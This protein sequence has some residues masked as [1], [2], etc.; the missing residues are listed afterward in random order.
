MAKDSSMFRRWGE[1]SRAFDNFRLDDYQVDSTINLEHSRSFR[2]ARFIEIFELQRFSIV[3]VFDYGLDFDMHRRSLPFVDNFE[4][5]GR[6]TIE[7]YLTDRGRGNLYPSTLIL[8]HLPLDRFNAVLSS[9][10][11]LCRQLQLHLSLGVGNSGVSSCLARCD[12]KGVSLSGHLSELVIENNRGAD[13]QQR[14][15]YSES[16]CDPLKSSHGILAVA[17]L[18]S[19]AFLVGFGMYRFYRGGS[20]T[21]L[22]V[23][24][25][26]SCSDRSSSLMAWILCYVWEG[27]DW[28]RRTLYHNSAL[29]LMCFIVVRCTT[30]EW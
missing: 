21:I 5:C 12:I 28:G 20:T 8:S 7:T 3:Q 4:L 15:N 11:L 9:L 1:L 26:A 30:N 2:R 18:S 23:S 29:N 19:G 14:P 6:S 13:G 27:P 17:S 25:V 10:G 16:D 24:F 22:L